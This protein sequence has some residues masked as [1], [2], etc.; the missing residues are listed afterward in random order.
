MIMRVRSHIK[1]SSRLVPAEDV[2]AVAVA[3]EEE[4]E[5]VAARA[6]LAN[7]RAAKP[8]EQEPLAPAEM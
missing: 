5:A 6:H 2:A 7:K 1:T 3:V 4:Q 8:Q